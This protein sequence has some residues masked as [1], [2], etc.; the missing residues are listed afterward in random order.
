MAK[1]DM[2]RKRGGK[3]SGGFGKMR[4]DRRARGGGTS[5]KNPYTAAGNVSSPDYMSKGGSPNAT[6]GAGGDKG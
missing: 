3:I 6:K 5:D 1:D 4:V 2:K